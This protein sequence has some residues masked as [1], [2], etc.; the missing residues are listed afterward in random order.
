[1]FSVGQELNAE[2]KI[3]SMQHILSQAKY[4][5]C[6]ISNEGIVCCVKNTD[7]EKGK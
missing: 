1:M 4:L 2:E 7:L 5:Y 6:H 3:L